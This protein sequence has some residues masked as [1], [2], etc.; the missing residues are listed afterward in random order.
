L[1][2]L[3]GGAELL[4]AEREWQKVFDELPPDADTNALPAGKKL[5]WPILPRAQH[6][7]HPSAVA[8]ADI[9]SGDMVENPD[10]NPI[11]G[12][13][14]RSSV[15]RQEL[16]LRNEQVRAAAALNVRAPPA[17]FKSDYIFMRKADGAVVLGCVAAV[18]F[19]GGVVDEAEVDVTEYEHTPQVGVPGFFGTFVAKPNP[20][21]NP[22]VSGSSKMVRHRHVARKKP[23]FGFNGAGAR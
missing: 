20:Q 23:I 9:A 17:I 1:R 19:G 18:P 5:T 8:S 2:S 6:V 7:V 15:V 13:H 11:A 16:L 21:Y 22:S 14:R 3:L 10:V 12:C 4:A